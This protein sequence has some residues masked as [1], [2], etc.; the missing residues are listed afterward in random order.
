M[1]SVPLRHRVQ[2]AVTGAGV[3]D[4][5]SDLTQA[6]DPMWRASPLPGFTPL[7]VD[8]ISGEIDAADGT[9]RHFELPLG[10]RGAAFVIEMY[11]AMLVRKSV[12]AP[13]PAF[14]FIINWR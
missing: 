12:M 10:C 13:S 8:R 6:V 14:P 3:S 1:R 11:L 2:F 5:I 4:G 9:I 7:T